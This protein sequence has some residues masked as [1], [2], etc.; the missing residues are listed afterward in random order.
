MYIMLIIG[1]NGVDIG[2]LGIFCIYV[3]LFFIL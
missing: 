3:M 2:V 1:F